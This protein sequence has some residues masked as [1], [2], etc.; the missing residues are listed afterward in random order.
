VAVVWAKLKGHCDA[1]PDKGGVSWPEENK[2]KHAAAASAGVGAQVK[3][4]SSSSLESP[5]LS[6]VASQTEFIKHTLRSQHAHVCVQTQ[7]QHL[8]NGLN[9]RSHAGAVAAER[10]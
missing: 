7:L 1:D 6:V 10:Q 4:R 9:V 3:E 2:M 8:I 5:L